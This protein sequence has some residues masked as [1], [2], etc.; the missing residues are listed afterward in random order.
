VAPRQVLVSLV[1][2][3]AGRRSN[4]SAHPGIHV[5]PGPPVPRCARRT[6][7]PRHRRPCSHLER[8]RRHRRLGVVVPPR[9]DRRECH[10]PPR[11][12]DPPPQ[13]T[14]WTAATPPPRRR[15]RTRGAHRPG[16]T[17]VCNGDR[18]SLAPGGDSLAARLSPDAAVSPA[19][20]GRRRSA[21]RSGR[22]DQ[23]PPAALRCRG[24]PLIRRRRQVDDRQ[25]RV[26]FA[27]TAFG[28]QPAGA[29][30][31]SAHREH[32]RSVA[33]PRIA[34]VLL[35]ANR[36]AKRVRPPEVLRYE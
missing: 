27:R 6:S 5:G 3:G 28:R 36:G 16:D 32:S 9:L 33:R 4:R 10:Y 19:A 11:Y 14:R 20:R 7:A 2:V 34:S 26:G 18:T 31:V 21:H 30:L 23:R 1:L 15:A 35:R 29:E 17:D 13:E 25:Y 24:G 8:P 22:T 12:A